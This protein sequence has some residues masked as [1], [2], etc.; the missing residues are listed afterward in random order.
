MT[1]K[2]IFLEEIDSTNEYVKRQSDLV[3]GTVVVASYQTQGKGQYNKRWEASP[4]ANILMTRLWK[5]SLVMT[6]SE[7]QTQI[8]LLLVSVLEEYRIAATIKSPNDILVNGKKIAG[9]LLETQMIDGAFDFYII[10]IG[11]N[12][13]QKEFPEYLID[14]TSMALERTR[15]FEIKEIL[16]LIIH[17]WEKFIPEKL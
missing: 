11:L 8:G 5:R 10:G 15:T 1:S 4:S 3:H 9:V 14:A 12:V 16:N 2:I 13:N 7:I 17:Q 6:T